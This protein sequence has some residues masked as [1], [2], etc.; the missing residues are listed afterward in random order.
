MKA[1][2]KW[3]WP[4][5][6]TP[7]S[8]CGQGMNALCE[9]SES[10]SVGITLQP[11]RICLSSSGRRSPTAQNSPLRSITAP[12]A[13]I[14]VPVD[15]SSSNRSRWSRRP[16]S[17]S[18]H[19]NVHPETSGD[20]CHRC[21]TASPAKTAANAACDALRACVPASPAPPLASQ[22]YPGVAELDAVFAL[23]LLVKMP[24]V[25]IEIAIAVES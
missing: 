2:R 1:N 23:Q 7:R 15:S 20:D 12:S 9:S 16:G 21:A 4:F 3:Q 6:Q 18:G 14:T 22:L 24:H 25:Q 17:R 8:P 11:V 5:Q 19:T 13:A 10:V